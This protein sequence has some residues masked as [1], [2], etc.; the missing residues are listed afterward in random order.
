MNPIDW[1][2]EINIIYFVTAFIPFYTQDKPND[3]VLCI[4][5]HERSHSEGFQ[6]FSLSV[7]LI[8]VLL[9]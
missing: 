5:T 6:H 1:Y 7:T 8:T 4:S 2:N 9:K 3:S